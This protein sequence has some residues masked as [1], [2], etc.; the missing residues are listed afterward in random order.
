MCCRGV[1]F[2]SVI[3]WNVTFCL[4]SLILWFFERV[5]FYNSRATLIVFVNRRCIRVF[6]LKCSGL[7]VSTCQM[8]GWKNPSGE[9]SSQSRRYLHKDK[10]GE[11]IMLLAL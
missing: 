9:T 1:Y 4:S 6:P 5:L 3:P 10:I 2:G 11:C 7:V 8:I